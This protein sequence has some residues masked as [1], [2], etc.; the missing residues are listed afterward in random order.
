M[1]ESL[2]D[3]Q[4]RIDEARRT[5][6]E[7]FERV[8]IIIAGGCIAAVVLIGAGAYIWS[9]L[10]HHSSL[11]HSDSSHSPRKKFRVTYLDSIGVK[12]EEEIED[13]IAFYQRV[14]QEG[15][16]VINIQTLK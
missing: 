16:S 11:H 12:R 5:F 9:K 14:R 13:T 8:G 1:A 15:L 10:E 2:E 7:I 3:I 6:D 4:K